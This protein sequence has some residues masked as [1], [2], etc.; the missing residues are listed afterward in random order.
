MTA[1]EELAGMTI[2]CSDKTGTLTLNKLSID[3][4]SFFT[5]GGYT[6]DQCMIFAARAS[7]TENQDAIDFAVVNS[8]PDPKMAR[9]GIEELDFHPFNPVD[10]RTEITYRD[11]KDGK[12]YKATKGAPQIILGMA[13]NKN[14]IEKQ[15]HE[16]IE[17]FAKRGFRALGIAVAE[18][19]SGEAHG[20]PGP[21]SMVG[22]MPI[23]DPPRHDTKET[24]EQAIAMGVEVKMITGDQLAIAK[25]T[26]SSSWNGHEYL[27]HGCAEFERPAGL[28]R[29]RWQCW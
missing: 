27:Q 18:V 12:V 16:Q 25:E 29:V 26:C 9:E 2:L 17:D 8:L 15:V 13:H 4:E 23:F 7:R 28:H 5:M 1:V 24:I 6:V 3:Q 21:W 20:E 11:N 22:L 10:K 19:P 14:E